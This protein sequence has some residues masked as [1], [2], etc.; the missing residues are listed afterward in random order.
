[1]TR[2]C[3]Y[4]GR[5]R[6]RSSASLTLLGLFCLGCGPSHGPNASL[7]LRRVILYQ[8]GLGYF[9][10]RG[11]IHE[12][13]LPLRFGAHEV[14]DVLSTLT[15]LEAGGEQTVVSASVPQRAEAEGEE[16]ENDEVTLEL[17]LPDRR[18]RDLTMTYA[19][20]TPAWRASYRVVLPEEPGEGDAL[21]QIWAL[22]HNASPENWDH[23]SLALATA[24]PISYSVDLRTPEFVERPD[25]NGRLVAP[26]VAGAVT[27]SRSRAGDPDRDGVPNGTDQCPSDPEDRDGF[28]DG[29]GMPRSRQRPGSHPRHGRH[30]PERSRDLQRT[31]GR[32][33]LPGSR[34]GHH[35]RE[36]PRHPRQALLRARFLAD[37]RQ[38]APDPG[39]HRR[40]AEREPAD[41]TAGNPRPRRRGRPPA[42]G[43]L[44]RARGDGAAGADR[45]RRL[46]R[47]AGGAFVRR[48]AAD[49]A[50]QRPGRQRAQPP[51]GVPGRRDGGGA[52]GP[53]HARASACRSR[54]ASCDAARAG[55][56]DGRRA[57]AEHPR[58]VHAGRDGGHDALRRVGAG[59]DPG[60]QL[61]AGHHPQRAGP[62]RGHPLLPP[63]SRGARE[64]PASLPRRADPQPGDHHAHPRA[65]GHL[66]GRELRGRGAGRGAA[67]GRDRDAAL[68]ARRLDAGGRRAGAGQRA[69]APLGDRARRDD[70]GGP[71]ESAAPGTPSRPAPTFR[72]ASSSS[73]A[74]RPG[75]RRGTCR[76]RPRRPRRPSSCRSRSRL[77]T[78]A[79]S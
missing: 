79:R 10:R 35:R 1:M 18:A 40:H 63:Q 33:R 60:P 44:G 41:P 6:I 72:R 77:G 38:S 21:F 30:V 11:D 27:A 53:A 64:R 57:R 19:V 32:G 24:A 43:D 25:V 9:E 3:A 78:P 8:N 54:A 70:G 61:L 31:G 15:V 62:R 48:L 65:G 46:R 17:T 52:A 45:A 67:R 58:R 73:T 16:G 29:D 34:G 55:G 49:P 69:G 28:A 12:D 23:V 20:P 42:S 76:P 75:T 51:G 66:R 26:H 4:Q 22:V 7:S 36:Q 74:A 2:V 68:R 71:L 13:R 37:P 39:R 5:M 56:G 14:D 50:R 59:V 47:P